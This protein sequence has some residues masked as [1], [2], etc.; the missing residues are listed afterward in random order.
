MK[1]KDKPDQLKLEDQ[2]KKK[3]VRKSVERRKQLRK[4]R[5][6]ERWA[7]LVLFVV[8]VFLGFVLW[9]SGEVKESGGEDK[10]VSPVKEEGASKPVQNEGVIVIE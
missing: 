1:K 4:K 6:Q 9:V 5:K 2:E 8:M 3:P 7:G 10:V